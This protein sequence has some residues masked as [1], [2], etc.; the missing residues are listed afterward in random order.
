MYRLQQE[1]SNAFLVERTS[2][3]HK[4]QE[5]PRSMIFVFHTLWVLKK[6]T[7]SSYFP[8]CKLFNK[9]PYNGLLQSPYNWVV[10]SHVYPKQQRVFSLL[11][12]PSLS[13][14]SN[15]F[16]NLCPQLSPSKTHL[17]VQLPPRAPWVWPNG[18]NG[19][20]FHQPRFP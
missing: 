14:S 20:I 9:D 1:K 2:N 3:H 7:K 10:L 6:K 15:P 18:I 5:G 19:I 8:L 16:T 4:S 12:L 11:I 17:Q 13:F